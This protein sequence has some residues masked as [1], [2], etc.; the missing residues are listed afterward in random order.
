MS[1]WLSGWA[2]HGEASADFQ[3]VVAHDQEL[4]TELLDRQDELATP[5]EAGGLET[6]GGGIES[7]SGGLDRMREGTY[8]EGT[9]SGAEAI[10]LRFT[11][12]VFLVQDSVVTPP[13]DANTFA[14][15]ESIVIESRMTAA[16]PHLKA[17]IPS[18]GR[19][20]APSTAHTRFGH[21][22]T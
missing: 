6:L 16:T 14:G 4:L 21:D 19:P 22:F 12:P 15:G 9:D 18:V 2:T 20:L 11:R 3:H 1:G 13:A 5:A 10:V 17:A 7:L 8:V